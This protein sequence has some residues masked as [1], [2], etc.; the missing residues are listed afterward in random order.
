MSGNIK[1][2]QGRRILA[3]IRLILATPS[4]Q[5][6]RPCLEEQ[7]LIVLMGKAAEL[8][9]VLRALTEQGNDGA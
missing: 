6:G 5:A 2:E 9:N 3:E 1:I 7:D 4:Y 8:E